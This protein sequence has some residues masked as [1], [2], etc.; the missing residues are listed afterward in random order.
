M[1]RQ[2][3]IVYNLVRTSDAV[4]G[5]L[6]APQVTGSIVMFGVIYALLFALWILLLNDKIQKGPEPVAENMDKT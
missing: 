3:W 1:G 6:T 2:P 4:S 5:N